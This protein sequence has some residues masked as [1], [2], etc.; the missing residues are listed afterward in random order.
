MPDHRALP[1]RD[2]ERRDVI[3]EDFLER[4]RA[5]SGARLALAARAPHEPAKAPEN[6]R[7]LQRGE[8]P[9]DAVDVLAD[10]LDEEDR[11]VE[12]RHVR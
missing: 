1:R 11:A 6:P 4:Q 3:R 5:E 8:H 9:I 7:Q 12:V 10:V 2:P